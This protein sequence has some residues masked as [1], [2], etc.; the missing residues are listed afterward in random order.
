MLTVTHQGRPVA[1]AGRTRV[2]LAPHIDALPRGHP[3]KCLVAF[4]ALYAP[5]ILTD[6]MP[7]PYTDADAE[8]FARLALI[9]TDVIARHPHATDAQLSRLLRVPIEQLQAHL[10]EIEAHDVPRPRPCGGR[11]RRLPPPRSN[12]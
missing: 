2:W 1:L 11:C 12:T 3:R 9:D 6:V 5:D 10:A 7:G 4:M 8:R